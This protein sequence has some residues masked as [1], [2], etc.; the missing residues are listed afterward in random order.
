MENQLRVGIDVFERYRARLFGI[1]YRMLGSVEDAEDIVQETSLRWHQADASAV[2]APEGWLVAVATRLSIDRLRRAATE[3]ELYT[4]TWLPEPIATDPAFETDRRVERASDLSMAFLVLLE[5]LSP[6]ERAALLMRDVFDTD[7]EEIA[8]VLDKSEA[9]CRQLV[10][11]ARARVRGDKARHAVPAETKERLL[12]QLLARLA[13]DDQPGVLALIADDATWNSDG[14]GKVA[15][16]RRVV[17]G[18]DRITRLLFGVQRKGQGALQHRVMWVNGE[19]AIVSY[20]S[21]R[22]AYTTSVL[23]DGERL[24]E[25]FRVLNP[26]KLRHIDDRG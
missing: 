13:A 5:R 23:T 16:T 24:L 10:H 8:S 7:Y 17:H 9:A 21:G 22:I 26:D 15:A 19:P 1:A 3:R 18:A 2:R 12:E 11:R 4:G 20:F 25:F 6:E 14:G